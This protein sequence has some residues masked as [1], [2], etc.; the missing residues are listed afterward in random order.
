MQWSVGLGGHGCQESAK[1]PARRE[2]LAGALAAEAGAFR[3]SRCTEEQ[4]DTS[5]L[6]SADGTWLV[7][8]VVQYVLQRLQSLVV[9][10]GI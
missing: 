1:S 2:E 9:D 10:S 3:P 5:H 8:R 6:R 4:Q 7:A